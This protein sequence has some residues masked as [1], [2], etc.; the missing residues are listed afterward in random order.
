MIFFN[1]RLEAF[2]STVLRMY[3]KFLFG[4]TTR[5]SGDCR[6][7]EVIID[8]FTK[9]SIRYNKLVI[10]EQI[11]SANVLTTHKEVRNIERL[12]EADGVISHEENTALII[13]GADCLPV[14]CFDPE[15]RFIAAAHV[16]WRGSLK[17][18]MGNLVDNLVRFGSKTQNLFMVLGPAINQCC[19]EIDVDT[20][21]E[22]MTH[23]ERFNK[24]AFRPHGSKYRMN[25][26]KLNYALAL[27]HGVLKE[28]I[29]FFPFCT[30]CDQNRFFS[31][32]RDFKNKPDQFGEMM[33]YILMT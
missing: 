14:V 12:E 15:S 1:T 16:G 5:D 24:L 33:G 25:L 6:K 23:M 8:Y 30:S 28:N 9:N 27:E 11:H 13:R 4:F 3:P 31:F 18:L 2:S 19:Y 10:L 26:L 29:D 21:G 17:N 7:T 22:F 20:Y 32:R